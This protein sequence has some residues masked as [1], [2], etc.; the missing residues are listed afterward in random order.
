MANKINSSSFFNRPEGDMDNPALDLANQ[1]FNISTAL[2]AQVSSLVKDIS[3]IQFLF[4]ENDTFVHDS[5][6]RLQQSFDTLSET[7]RILSGDVSGLSSKFLLLEQNRAK[8]LDAES[9][10]LFEKEDAE[11]K[12]RG[13]K[14]G[15][16]G[17]LFGGGSGGGSGGVNQ[18]DLSPDDG[19]K[20]GI[21]GALKGM[22][23]FALVGGLMK[24]VT[25]LV[26]GV[27]SIGKGIG[28]GLKSIGESVGNGIKG[29]KSAIG[30]G[31]K[32][33]ADFLTG[34]LTDFD[35]KGKGKYNLFGDIKGDGKTVTNREVK[36]HHFDM[37]TGKAYIDG[38]EVPLE[39][40]EE[41]KAMP[42]EQ[43]LNDPRFSTGDPIIPESDIDDSGLK[44]TGEKKATSLF[45]G[46][47]GG[48]E[49]KEEK[50]KLQELTDAG[51]KFD[52]QG[53]N[54]MNQRVINYTGPEH[55]QKFSKGLMGTLGIGNMG[56]YKKNEDREMIL[57]GIGR[58]EGHDSLE[59]IVA[60]DKDL[61]V[62]QRGIG[63][64]LLGG[65]DA[66]TGNITD[67]DQKGGETFGSGRAF[68]GL[69]DAATGGL[70]DMDKKGGKPFG[71]MRGLTGTVDFLTGNKFDLDKR[72]DGKP[73]G[74]PDGRTEPIVT[75]REV[76]PHHY[77]SKTGKAYIDGEEV[78]LELYEEFK[79]MP[80]EQQL[81]DQRFSTGDPI[82]PWGQVPVETDGDGGSS[83]KPKLQSNENSIKDM[84]M[85]VVTTPPVSDEIRPIIE[86][87]GTNTTSQENE[88]SNKQ[89]APPVATTTPVSGTT[90]TINCINM[91]KSNS[92]YNLNIG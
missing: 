28:N 29:V 83:L 27:K 90:C 38:E 57:S 71:L 45:G 21:G 26:D 25:S 88:S 37:E 15:A 19:A 18:E 66:A 32:G 59:D 3:A 53:V 40:Y 8:Q 64:R 78:P 61:Q 30:D 41:F 39:L 82:K 24:G 85:E 6:L 72:G 58:H 80:H 65:I 73:D 91:L 84:I 49:K 35:G 22:A 54:A 79:A 76:K 11:Q 31:I 7:V 87:P 47:F 62:P 4:Q 20:G 14:G 70:T 69:V 23:A 89:G 16:F 77:D 42:H 74:K 56:R 2:Q 63:N 92:V 34:G 36:P 10:R 48:G 75:R 13:N 68:G 5:F 12:G 43:K 44:P 51:Y 55:G 1:S 60:R 81:K 67:F 17:G 9:L 52:D 33:T 86:V 46:L 50:S